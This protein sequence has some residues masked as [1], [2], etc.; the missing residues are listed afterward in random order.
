[1]RPKRL[2]SRSNC[3]VETTLSVIGGVWKPLIL[4]HLLSGTKRFMELTRLIPAAT[5]RMLTLQLRE[6]EADGIVLRNVY[7]E[8]PPKVEYTLSEFGKTLAPV[9]C[10]LR[11]WGELFQAKRGTPPTSHGSPEYSVLSNQGCRS[12]VGARDAGTS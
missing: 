6:L 7:P 10:A 1:M 3:A 11:D 2:D 5:Q 9:L 8:V 4:F 12:L